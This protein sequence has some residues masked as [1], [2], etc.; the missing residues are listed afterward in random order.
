LKVKGQVM[1]L[2]IELLITSRSCRVSCKW[3]IGGTFLKV[4]RCPPIVLQSIGQP[5]CTMII[6]VYHV[7]ICVCNVVEGGR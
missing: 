3:F 7:L 5:A 6:D 2:P 4:L 1:F